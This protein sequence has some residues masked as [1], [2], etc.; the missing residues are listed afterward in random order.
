MR[1]FHNLTA[2]EALLTE[3]LK[4]LEDIKPMSKRIE[5]I[6][7]WCKEMGPFATDHFV[8]SIEDRERTGVVPLQELI[9]ILGKEKI[10]ALGLT[11]TCA[12]SI[13]HVSRLSD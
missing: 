8:C 1:Q 11:K 9:E 5:E 2:V 3:Y 12:F 4:L 13:V 10:E 7:A 6:R